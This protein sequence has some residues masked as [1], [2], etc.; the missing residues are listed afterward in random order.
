QQLSHFTLSFDRLPS[1]SRTAFRWQFFVGGNWHNGRR[2]WQFPSPVYHRKQ[3]WTPDWKRLLPWPEY[4]YGQT[5]KQQGQ[6]LRNLYRDSPP[7]N[8]NTTSDCAL[9]TL[10]DLLV[11]LCAC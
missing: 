7:D 11:W 5:V 10:T 9:L 6:T 2:T 8:Q 3:C 4:L 1:Q